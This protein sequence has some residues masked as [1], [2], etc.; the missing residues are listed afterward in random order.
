MD[1]LEATVKILMGCKIVVYFCFL[2]YP[3]R[4]VSDL[5]TAAKI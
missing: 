1:L 4:I 2:N 3:Y 5:L